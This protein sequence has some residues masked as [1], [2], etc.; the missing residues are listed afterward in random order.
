[1]PFTALEI[2]DGIVQGNPEP[3]AG[4][5]RKMSE[6]DEARAK[7]QLVSEVYNAR[8]NLRRLYPEI[9]EL[10]GRPLKLVWIPA[11]VEDEM[12]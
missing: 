4:R 6:S 5:L 1:M 2:V 12:I 8:Y 10:P 7:A 9:Q 11:Q 3:W